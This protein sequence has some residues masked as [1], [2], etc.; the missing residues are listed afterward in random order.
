MTAPNPE[1]SYIERPQAARERRMRA[2][3]QRLVNALGQTAR[4]IDRD[5]LLRQMAANELV[6]G[7]PEHDNVRAE[8]VESHIRWLLTPP[9]PIG[10]RPPR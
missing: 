5:T 3:A 2:F 9:G 4:Q 1:G 8:F 10:T 6:T 7:N